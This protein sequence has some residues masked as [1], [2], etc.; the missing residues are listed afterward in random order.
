MSFAVM[1]VAILAAPDSWYARDLIRAADLAGAGD[2]VICVDFAQLTSHVSE[3]GLVIGSGENNLLQWDAVIVRTMPP[4]SLEQVVAR[5]DVLHLCEAGGVCV[6]NPPRAVEVSVDKY[7]ATARLQ[8]AGL[9]VPATWMG[10]QPADAWRAFH[11]LGGDVVC[12]PL[13]GSEGR[14]IFRLTDPDLAGRAFAALDRIQSVVYLQRYVPHYGYDWRVLVVGQRLWGMRRVH[15]S[16]WRTNIHRGARAE[17]LE[18]SAEIGQLALRA[19]QAVGAR[20]A[21]VDLLPGR[22]GHLY[23]LEVNAVPGWRALAEANQRDIAAALWSDL[24]SV[25]GQNAEGQEG[26]MRS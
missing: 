24:R 10:Q 6:M 13:F 7:L 9:R 8:A 22:D 16:D 14:G 15:T 18:I 4:G 20:W 11:A 1:R 19:A 23:V 2:Q 26:G 5:M 25:V 21:G 17:R 3:S 12:K